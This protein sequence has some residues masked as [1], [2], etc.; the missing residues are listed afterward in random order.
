MMPGLHLLCWPAKRHTGRESPSCVRRVCCRWVA[1]TAA[2]PLHPP[3]AA[4]T[5]CHNSRLAD[6]LSCAFPTTLSDGRY[7][8]I[9]KC[10]AGAKYPG[11]W[12]VPLW[13]LSAKGGPYTMVS[14]AVG[15]QVAPP[16]GGWCQLLASG[17]IVTVLFQ[18]SS[19]HLKHG[20]WTAAGSAGPAAANLKQTKAAGAA[21][22]GH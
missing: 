1:C 18:A 11:V 16:A 19:G 10:P 9:Q 14:E 21:A 4:C 22:A 12:Q 6:T 8:T 13:D 20:P 17:G 2:H 7:S 3:T 5:L 15:W